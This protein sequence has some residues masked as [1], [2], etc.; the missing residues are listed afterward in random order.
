MKQAAPPVFPLLRSQLQAGLL[1]RLFVGQVEESVSELAAAVR[2]DAGNTLRE[3]E[4]LERGAIVLT[5]RVGRTRLVRANTTAPFYQALHD[6][7]VITMGPAQVLTRAL[8]GLDGVESASVIGSWA[9]RVLGEDGPAPQDID[10]LVVGTPDPDKLRQRT[11]QA[12]RTLG[13]DVD[14]EVV[15]SPQWRQPDAR[16]RE[17]ATGP[18]VPVIRPPEPVRTR[19]DMQRART[20][21]SARAQPPRFSLIDLLGTD[22]AEQGF[23][24]AS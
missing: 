10:L 3:V 20:D 24:Q 22:P 2:A 4:R 17:L 12:A 19:P 11:D 5:R 8:A 23:D 16:V 1:V 21:S 7:I 15:T 9:A 13:R 6:L 18:Q 14:V